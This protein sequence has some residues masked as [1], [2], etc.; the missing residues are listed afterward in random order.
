M[1]DSKTMKL[2]IIMANKLMKKKDEC[3]EC[4]GTGVGSPEGDKCGHCEGTGEK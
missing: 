4:S 1:K 2:L 3:V